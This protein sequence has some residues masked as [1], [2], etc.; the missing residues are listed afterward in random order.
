[1]KKFLQGAPASP[2]FEECELHRGACI[3]NGVMRAILDLAFQELLRQL[4]QC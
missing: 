4:P 2:E 3:I 1:M